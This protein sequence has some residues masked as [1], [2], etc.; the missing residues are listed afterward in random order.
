MNRLITS[1]IILAVMIAGCVG[2]VV[3]VNSF[4]ERIDSKINEV[5]LAFTENDL[6]KSSQAARE[7]QEEWDTFLK[8][9]I[10]VN[11]LGHAIELTSAISEVYSFALEG[12]E[13]IYASCDRVQAQMKLF[14]D[15]QTPTIWKI[16]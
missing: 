11:D 16:L 15:M 2:S 8:Y 12:N 1:I 9:S 10:F 4:T 6:E 7:L 14:R 3:W 5:E 13:E